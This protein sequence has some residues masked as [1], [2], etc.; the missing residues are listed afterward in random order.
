MRD[1]G[2][3]AV[4]LNFCMENVF[5]LNEGGV[6]F[7]GSDIGWVVGHSF[8]VYGPLIRCSKAIFF[9]GKPIVPDAGVMWRVCEQYKVTSLY[10]APTGVRV[11]KK[12]D[13]EGALV[14]KYDVSSVRTFCLVG[15]RCDPDTIHW[16]RRHFP[17]VLINDTWWQTETGWPIS[18]NLLNLNN[19]KTVWPT[20]PGSVTR[21]VPGYEVKIFDESNNPV[22]ADT[23]GKVVIKLPLPP[24]FMLTLWGNDAAFI[25][26]YLAD[27][28]GYYTTGDAGVIDAKGY[29]HIMTRMDD[30]INTAGHRISTGRLEEVVNNHDLVVESAVVGYNHEVRGECPLAFVILRGGA[31]TANMSAEDKANLAKEINGKVRA[32]VG[33]FC[34]LEGVLF[35]AKLPKTRS[36][37]ILRGTIRK[38][39]NQQEYAYPAT[40]DDPTS[41]D[42]I[43]TLRDEFLA[44]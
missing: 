22:P 36:G 39:V 41:L 8:I 16:V 38:I 20:L 4:G 1:S 37:K 31:D 25:E 33:A 30:V 34:R 13:Y 9:E 21:S 24:A 2:G 28:P 27:T 40:I 10:M 6:H 18:A 11:I 15:E 32:D 42:L 14:K 19:F 12:D 26:K 29:L 3:T 7:A 43:K 35:L 44:T 17:K 23:L 5:D